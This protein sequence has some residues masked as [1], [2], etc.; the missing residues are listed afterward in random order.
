MPRPWLAVPLSSWHKQ[1]VVELRGRTVWNRYSP[2]DLLVIDEAHHAAADSWTRAMR[3]W[4]GSIV[5]MTATPWRL[6]EKEGF[7]H[8]F[9][10]LLW[11][12]SNRR[13]AGS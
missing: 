13:V 4:P 5:G 7:K 10:D 2:E 9:D 1:W 8:L 12:P 3:Q 11:R 6:S